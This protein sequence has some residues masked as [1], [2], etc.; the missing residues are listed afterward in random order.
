MNVIKR[1]REWEWKKK[2]NKG[3]RWDLKKEKRTKCVKN[4]CADVGYKHV[5]SERW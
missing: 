5:E 3:M 4:L 1:V 2:M